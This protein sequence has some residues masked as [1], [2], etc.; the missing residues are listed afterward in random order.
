MS[1]FRASQIALALGAVVLVGACEDDPTGPDASGD[2]GT[3]ATRDDAGP[4]DGSGRTDGSGDAGQA[5]P[6]PKGLPPASALGDRRGLEIA[7]ATIHLHSPISHDACD[8]EGWA[9]GGL[10]DEACL[11]HLREAA[12]TLRMDALM[13]TDHAPHVN[14]VGFRQALWIDE[15]EGDEPVMAPDGSLVANR[16]ACGGDHRVLVT[17]GSENALMPVALRGH[18]LDDAD[19]E[20]L[21]DAYE[22]DGPAAVDAFRNAGGLALVP[23]TESRSLDYLRDLGADGMEIYNIHANVDPEIRPEHLGLEPFGYAA[24]LLLFT[25]AR[26]ELEPDLAVLTFLSEN[27]NA[28][29][30]WDAL[31]AEG[32]RV[33]GTG[34]CDAHENALPQEL[35]DGERADSYRR[36]MK[37]VTNHLLVEERSFDAMTAAVEHGRMYVAFEAFGTPVGFDF[38]AEDGEG[39]TYE[40]GDAAPAGV[41]LR[42][43]RPHLPDG[44]PAEPPPEVRLRLVRSTPSGAV[45]VA[46]SAD[47]ELTLRD[48]E[49]GVYRAEARIVPEHA[50]P[51]LDRLADRL[52]KGYVWVYA[53]PIRVAPASDGGT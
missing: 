25:D 6:W 24:D 29:D 1:L 19:A 20:A 42:V 2:A 23:H 27:D 30:K 7:R 43:R 10:A 11:T 40:M 13:L 53:N 39:E 51:Y 15:D 36:M 18:V 46:T 48:V 38:F 5:P 49:P 41:T 21:G 45:E 31:L 16:M 4:L 50:R 35:A 22:A 33:T 17:A 37:W 26:L 47:D 32:R 12:C 8:G 9:D 14:E 3:D 44:H 52:V 34:G 28:L